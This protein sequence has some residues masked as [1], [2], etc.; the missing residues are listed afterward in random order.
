MSRSPAQIQAM[1]DGV[2][3][4]VGRSVV[5]VRVILAGTLLTLLPHQANRSVVRGGQARKMGRA[6]RDYRAVLS[7][8]ACQNAHRSTQA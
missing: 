3:S 5:P 6:F 2:S 8:C 1:V 7:L 4:S